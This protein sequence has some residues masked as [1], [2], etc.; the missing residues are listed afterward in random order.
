[1]DAKTV[2]SSYQP[3]VGINILP[4]FSGIRTKHSES[5]TLKNADEI[6]LF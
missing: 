3:D 2:Q 6:T 1:M 4:N 5:L